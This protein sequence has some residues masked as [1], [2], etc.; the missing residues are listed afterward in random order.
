MDY[1]RA[2]G[3]WMKTLSSASTSAVPA[4]APADLAAC[5]Q[6]QSPTKKQKVNT[7]NAKHVKR[8]T[9]FGDWT[10]AFFGKKSSPQWSTL[11]AAEEGDCGA[12]G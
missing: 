6:R 7:A 2:G 11:I 9:A 3:R 12:R 1:V 10:V 8:S 4:G 5:P